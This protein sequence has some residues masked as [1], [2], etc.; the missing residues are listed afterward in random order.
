MKYKNIQEAEQL[1][2]RYN[3]ISREEIMSILG[4]KNFQDNIIDILN[5]LT[6]FSFTDTCTLC[7]TGYSSYSQPQ[8]CEACIYASGRH[9]PNLG[10]RYYCLKGKHKKT[11]NALKKCKSIDKLLIAYKNRANHISKVL[12]KIEADN[13]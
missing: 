8:P 4:D 12:Q 5:K 3:S 6:G 9:D 1:I 10:L 2:A 7:S 11:Y 13:I